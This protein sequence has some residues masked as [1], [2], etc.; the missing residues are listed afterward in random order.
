MIVEETPKETEP[1]LTTRPSFAR[2]ALLLSIGNIASR[3][4]GLVREMVIARTFEPKLVGVFTV[5]SQVPTLLY[6]LLIGGMLSAALVPVLSAYAQQ[7]RREFVRLV[8]VLITLFTCLL[9]L[10]ALL[11]LWGA[12]T[13]T[14]LL[15]GG[16]DATDPHLFTLTTT[17]IRLVTPAIWLFGMAGVLTAVLY[18]LQ[19]FTWPALATA[20]APA[21]AFTA[22]TAPTTATAPTIGN[23]G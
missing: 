20:L 14:W 16:F 13:V 2:S 1:Q 5:A 4:L 23:S 17:L 22:A 15:A 3:V 7:D 19:R 18:A 21:T 6:D 12:P 9:A 11:L 10:L 8:N